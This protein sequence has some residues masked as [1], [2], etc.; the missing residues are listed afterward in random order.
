MT[1]PFTGQLHLTEEVFFGSYFLAVVFF[2]LELAVAGGCRLA[3]LLT[4]FDGGA[5]PVTL[6][7]WPG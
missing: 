6:I 5:L 7:L 4:F 1:L 2:L 3:D